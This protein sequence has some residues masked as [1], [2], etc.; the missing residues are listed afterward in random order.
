ML[1]QFHQ[2]ECLHIVFHEMSI[3]SG[4]SWLLRSSSFSF[5]FFLGR[6]LIYSHVRG[7]WSSAYCPSPSFIPAATSTAAERTHDGVGLPLCPHHLHQ[8]HPS[9]T[10]AKQS[11]GVACCIPCLYLLG[12]MHKCLHRSGKDDSVDTEPARACLLFYKLGYVIDSYK[13]YIT[14]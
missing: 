10:S 12:N 6:M 3:S 2:P 14:K 5:I 9:F 8:S 4:F 7:E 1:P 13:A 11:A